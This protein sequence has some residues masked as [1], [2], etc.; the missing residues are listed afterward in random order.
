MD[1]VVETKPEAYLQKPFVADQII[2]RV[3]RLLELPAALRLA[4]CSSPGQ[5]ISA[6]QVLHSLEVSP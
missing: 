3:G 4:G 5:P 2:E 1:M 6:R